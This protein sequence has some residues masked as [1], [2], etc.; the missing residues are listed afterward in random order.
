VGVTPEEKAKRLRQRVGG[1]IML[2]MNDRA[3]ELI[4]DAL[5]T[6]EEESLEACAE[7]WEQKIIPD[8]WVWKAKTI[9]GWLRARAL[10]PR[11]LQDA[12][13]ER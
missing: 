1:Y 12:P 10:A 8:D 5:R 6:T 13:R 3:D 11:N 7:A 2:G 9:A 4:A